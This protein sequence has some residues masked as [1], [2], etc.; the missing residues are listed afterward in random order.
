ML[1]TKYN[2]TK[3]IGFEYTDQDGAWHTYDFEQSPYEIDTAKS[4]EENMKEVMAI[5]HAKLQELL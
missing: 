4:R 3:L 5:V 1:K 2:S